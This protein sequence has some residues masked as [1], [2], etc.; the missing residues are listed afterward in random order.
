MDSNGGNLGVNTGDLGS[1]AGDLS[2]NAG[3]LDQLPEQ[4]SEM[5]NALSPRARKD[6]I[7]S[8]ILWLCAIQPMKAESL[9]GL[10]N[11][12]IKALKESHLNILRDQDGFIE[13]LYPEVVNHPG[14]AYKATSKGKEWLKQ[15]GIGFEAS[16]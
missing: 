13:Y 1:N 14:Q 15:Q 16:G 6:K 12:K 2:S 9:A 7:R 8:I 3:D 11:R 5:I 4:L 10:L